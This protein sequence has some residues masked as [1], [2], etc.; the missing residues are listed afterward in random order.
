MAYSSTEA[1]TQILDDMAAAVDELAVALA[2]LTEAYEALDDDGATA[3]EEHIFRPVQSGYGR[4]RRTHA[5]FAVRHGLPE[6]S[7]TPRSP[8]T[9]SGDP[10]VYIERALDATEDAEQRLAEL[11]DSMLPVEVGDPP[12]RAGLAETRAVLAAVPAQGRLL[13]RT[14]GR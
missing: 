2:S 7:F 10:R 8:G 11:Q 1:R 3:L 13:L 4:L 12:L 14:F 9:H 6:R 5:E